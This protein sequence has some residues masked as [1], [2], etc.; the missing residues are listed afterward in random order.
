MGHLVQGSEGKGRNK[1]ARCAT[2]PAR[3][4]AVSIWRVKDGGHGWT[5]ISRSRL[6]TANSEPSRLSAF[7]V[8]GQF[9]A[10][11]LQAV[12]LAVLLNQRIGPRLTF[13]S[14]PLAKYP[15]EAP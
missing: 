4:G 12:V 9:D 1:L 2:G 3:R 5:R 7:S 6:Q 11:H 13:I 15:K 14:A 8:V 10:R